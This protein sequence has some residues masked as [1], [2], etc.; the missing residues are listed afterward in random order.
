MDKDPRYRKFKLI[1]TQEKE[2]KRKKIEEEKQARR[3]AE[4]Q[5]LKEYREELA[6]QYQQ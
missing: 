1:Q 3:E 6:R 2:A 5:R 4:A